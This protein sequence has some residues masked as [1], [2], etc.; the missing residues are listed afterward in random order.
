M[1]S[2]RIPTDSSAD[3]TIQP[4]AEP[5]R[6]APLIAES[7]PRA[8]NVASPSPSSTSTQ[9]MN[10]SSPP[11]HSPPQAIHAI[12]GSNAR[13]E[14]HIPIANTETFN[15]PDLRIPIVGQA[16]SPDLFP[17]GRVSVF[18]LAYRVETFPR[19]RCS[20]G[21]LIHYPDLS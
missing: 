16:R 10:G 19:S 9:S 8:S 3:R 5:D 4:I 20:C 11:S 14:S 1:A 18:L 13:S 7:D 2:V 12:T 6:A 17:S 21:V 15:S